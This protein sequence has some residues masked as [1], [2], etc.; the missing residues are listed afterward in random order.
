MH[1][2][3]DT[4]EACVPPS[5][6][7]AALAEVGFEHIERFSSWGVLSEYVGRK[8]A[9][10]MSVAAGEP[11]LDAAGA[12][13]E[14]FY[15]PVAT[16]GRW[17]ADDRVIALLRFRESHRRRCAKIHERCRSHCRC[18]DRRNS[19]KSGA[20]RWRRHEGE[21]TSSSRSA[22]SSERTD[23]DANQDEPDAS[24]SFP[25]AIGV[26]AAVTR[27]STVS[28]CLVSS[29]I[30]NCWDGFSGA[31]NLATVTAETRRPNAFPT[32]C[33]T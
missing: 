26:V 11:A 6:I 5:T 10:A 21:R 27:K 33:S 2:Y 25:L 7:M 9:E 17:L 20:R 18:S 19:S 14:G 30:L 23:A 29:S 15:A 1:F 8:P 28:G 31:W 22:R 4:I 32:A 12:A 13:M 3:W 24:R 16:A